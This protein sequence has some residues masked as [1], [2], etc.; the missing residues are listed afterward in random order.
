MPRPAPHAAELAALPLRT[1]EVAILGSTTRYWDYGPRDATR[2]LVLCHGYRGDHHGLEPVVARL[3]GVRIVSPDL[4]GFGESTPMTEQPHSIDGYARWFAAFVRAL[5]L[6]DAVVLGHSFGSIVTT[7][8]VAAGLTPPAL[9]LVNP[10]ASDPAE[11][12]GVGVTKLYYGL[13]R[14]LPE[15][16]GR[17][18]LAS[19]LIVAVMSR[20]LVKTPDRELRKWIHEEHGRYFSRFSDVRTVAEGFDASLSAQ[21]GDAADAVGVPTLLIAGDDDMIAPAAGARETVGRFR[22]GRLVVL[23]GVGHLV[24]YEAAEGAADAITAFLD[25]VLT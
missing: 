20:T 12:G 1:G 2:T 3:P 7:H 22:D 25:E 4:P 14:R 16:L 6:E 17:A 24:H 10:I 21:V 8:A 5:G 9:I 23:P 11:V 19:P 18:L 13:A 15:R